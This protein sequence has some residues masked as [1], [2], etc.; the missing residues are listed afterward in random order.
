MPLT[1][2]P[3]VTKEPLT[4]LDR[5]RLWKTARYQSFGFIAVTDRPDMV[6]LDRYY[7]GWNN[8]K[9]RLAAATGL[10]SG[11]FERAPGYDMSLKNADHIAKLL[12]HLPDLRLAAEGLHEQIMSHRDAD[13]AGQIGELNEIVAEGDKKYG[14]L[15]TSPTSPGRD[16]EHYVAN[17]EGLYISGEGS[18]FGPKPGL[19]LSDKEG[20][21]G[22]VPEGSLPFGLYVEARG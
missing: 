3:E 20:E 4:P 12:Y 19:I 2:S 8:D 22:L 16:D 13:F 18:E 15:I 17:L 5:R 6:K 21:L 10:I 1:T 14:I 7:P 11:G 9:R